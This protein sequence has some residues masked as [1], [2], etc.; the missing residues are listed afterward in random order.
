MQGI[1]FGLASTSLG[2]IVAQIVPDARKGEGMSYYAVFL[3]LSSAVGPYAS[4]LVY[5]D[6]NMAP[7][8]VMAPVLV[9]VSIVLALSIKAPNPSARAAGETSAEDESEH[10]L[11]ALLDRRALPISVVMFFMAL[12]WASVLSFMS[13]FCA[14]AGLS[15]YAG[16]FYVSYAL[17]TVVSRL[18]TGRLFDQ[19]GANFVLYP[20]FPLFAAALLLLAFASSGW[21]VVLSGTLVAWVMARSSPVHRRWPYRRPT[22]GISVLPPRRSSSTWTS[23]T[24]WVRRCWAPWRHLPGIARCIS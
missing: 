14:Q 13:S 8:L 20:T 6:A 11:G 22:L 4:A 7:T 1:G 10:G 9:L 12:G 5:H 24:G 21:Q 3:T 19:R 23:P 16:A 15:A 17:L 2:T 18:F